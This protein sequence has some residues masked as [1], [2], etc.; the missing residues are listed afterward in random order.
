MQIING[1]LVSIIKLA[2]VKVQNP[3]IN[4]INAGASAEKHII[5]SLLK[6]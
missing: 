1:L 6:T 5:V 4:K 3:K 2:K